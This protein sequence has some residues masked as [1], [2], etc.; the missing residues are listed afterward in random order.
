MIRPA[1]RLFVLCA[2]AIAALGC[3]YTLVGRASNI[4]ETIRKVHLAPLENAT[5]RAQVDQILTRALADELVT[6]RRF[7]LTSTATDADAEL[8]GTVVAFAVNPVSFDADGR[9]TEYEIVVNARMSFRQ[10]DP[11]AILW[12]N[13]RY[14]FRDSYELEASELGYFDRETPAIEATAKRFAETMVTDLLEGF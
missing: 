8:R 6:R 4:P 11:E 5:S 7:E 14:Q 12:Q 10:L 2:I 3:G 9:A 1:R 13:D